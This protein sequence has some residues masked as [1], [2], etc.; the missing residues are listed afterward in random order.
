MLICCHGIFFRIILLFT[1]YHYHLWSKQPEKHHWIIGDPQTK[2]DDAGFQISTWQTI[3]LPGKRKPK[4]NMWVSA[5]IRSNHS[6]LTTASSTRRKSRLIQGT[7]ALQK[8]N[9]GQHK[10]SSRPIDHN[11]LTKM[12]PKILVTKSG[13]KQRKKKLLATSN[14]QIPRYAWWKTSQHEERSDKVP[15]AIGPVC[16]EYER[17]KY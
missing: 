12:A 6:I 8:N 7:T 16:T 14:N 13:G 1:K 4:Y 3:P 9:T 17:F 10:P 2:K 5:R 11:M 15:K